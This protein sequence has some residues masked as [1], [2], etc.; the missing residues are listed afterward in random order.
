[1]SS[2]PACSALPSVRAASGLLSVRAGSGL[3]STFGAGSRAAPRGLCAAPVVVSCSGLRFFAT[4]PAAR[5]GAGAPLPAVP[6]PP[7]RHRRRASARA[8]RHHRPGALLARQHHHAGADLHPRV[9]VG[10]V[11]IGEADAVRRYEAADGRGLVG[12]VDAVERIAE[13]ERARAERIAVA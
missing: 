9:E 3:L 13:I 1:Y 4:S 12:A 7:P 5:L 10:D 11:L 8:H 6:A 2:N